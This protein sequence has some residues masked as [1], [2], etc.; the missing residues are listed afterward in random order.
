MEKTSPNALIL[1]V[2]CGVVEGVSLL[3]ETGDGKGGSLPYFLHGA[4]NS[5]FYTKVYFMLEKE[6][7]N[8][9]S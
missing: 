8:L 1:K 7:V 3:A 9:V 5:S 6:C 4:N 2:S